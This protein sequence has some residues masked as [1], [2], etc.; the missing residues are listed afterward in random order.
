MNPERWAKPAIGQSAIRR[1]L[2][3]VKLEFTTL[4]NQISACAIAKAGID[5]CSKISIPGES[6]IQQAVSFASEK[7]TIPA[8][9]QDIL[10]LRTSR[11]AIDTSA[12]DALKNHLVQLNSSIKSLDADLRTQNK[13]QGI[14]EE[15]LRVCQE[16]TIPKLEDEIQTFLQLI[17]QKYYS[18]WVESTGGL[19][20]QRELTTRQSAEDIYRAFPRELARSTNAK[21][22]SWGNLVEL[23][24]DYNRKYIMGYD[25]KAEANDAYDDA[26]L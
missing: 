24:Q 23:R 7:Q 22:S 26:C 21:N 6:D 20:Y 11:A 12:I 25:T 14:L 19:R 1:R 15:R 16:E 9:E 10:R 17:D 13:E 3:A 4:T 2:D 8:L 18:E 5:L